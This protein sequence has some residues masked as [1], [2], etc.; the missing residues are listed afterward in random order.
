MWCAREAAGKA[1]GTGLSGGSAA[2]RVSALDV[3]RE[4]LLID[5]GG[6]QLVAW[7]HREQELVVATTLD[8]GP[9]SEA[10]R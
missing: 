5:A 8:P 6:R 4:A 7:T 10:P 1:L 9:G 3:S 2:P